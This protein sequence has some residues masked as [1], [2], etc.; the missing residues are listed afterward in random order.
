MYET[1]ERRANTVPWNLFCDYIDV[2]PDEEK[3]EGDP[4]GA[5]GISS[6]SGEREA[7]YKASR[8]ERKGGSYLLFLIRGFQKG[9]GV[10]EPPARYSR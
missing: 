5:D 7:I 2:I 8:A 10:P 1:L 3:V 4:V 6:G 9:A